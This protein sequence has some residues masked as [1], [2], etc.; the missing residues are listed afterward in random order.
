MGSRFQDLYF[1]WVYTSVYD[2]TVA[3]LEAYRRRATI[4]SVRLV[5]AGALVA[6][7]AV[8]IRSTAG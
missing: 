1:D 2:F 3:Q 5:G 4:W 6:A 7:L 8:G